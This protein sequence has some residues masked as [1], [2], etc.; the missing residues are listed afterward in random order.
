MLDWKHAWLIWR[1]HKHDSNAA[2]P[3][4]G[5]IQRQG[6]RRF[7]TFSRVQRDAKAHGSRSASKPCAPKQLLPSPVQEEPLA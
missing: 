7:R 1:S 5:T 6:Q 2:V 4:R 3:L